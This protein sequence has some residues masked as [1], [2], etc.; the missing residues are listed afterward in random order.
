VSFFSSNE[1]QCRCGCGLYQ[2]HPG[3]L[4]QLEK[5][6]VAFNEPMNVN[7]GCRCIAHNRSV[8][9]TEKSLH[10]GDMP[11]HKDQKGTLAVDI[12]SMNGAYRGRLIS[13]AWDFGWSAGWG[14]GF[15]HLD[16]RAD[17]GLPQTTFDY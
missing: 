16:R 14:K 12:Q 1:L 9:G 13:L 15:L 11:Q 4:D 2:F 17:I 7:S 3:F 8:G 6:R 10:I 5:L